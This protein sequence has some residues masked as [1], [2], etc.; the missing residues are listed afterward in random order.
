MRFL[1]RCRARCCS[2]TPTCPRRIRTRVL[3]PSVSRRSSQSSSCRA[4]R[5]PTICCRPMPPFASGRKYTCSTCPAT[6]AEADRVFDGPGRADN[7]GDP[8]RR[9]TALVAWLRAAR[10]CPRAT[11]SWTR[12]SH[13]VPGIAATGSP[14]GPMPRGG[15]PR[16]E[17]G[18]QTP[19]P[20]QANHVAGRRPPD[21]VELARG[22]LRH[23]HRVRSAV[24]APSPAQPWHRPRRPERSAARDA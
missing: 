4:W 8:A 1:P 19:R 12:A 6:P 24:A 15:R 5:S 14:S 21:G 2:A 9:A 18:G 16:I 11:R 20:K 3:R 23:A 17:A 22:D 13:A 7:G 10:W